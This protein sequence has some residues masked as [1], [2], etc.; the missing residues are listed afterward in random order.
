[1]TSVIAT[2]AQPVNP[3]ARG[4]LADMVG[5][6]WPI[7]PKSTSSRSESGAPAVS[8]IFPRIRIAGC[9]PHS[10]WAAHV[11]GLSGTAATAA[12]YRRDS[13]EWST[14]CERRG[15]DPLAAREGH[16]TAWVSWLGG[17]A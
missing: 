10:A 9:R 2:L 7:R 4:R 6:S 8:P 1:M 15:V 12:A 11:P 3:A 13:G 16:R 14:W 17:C 5:E